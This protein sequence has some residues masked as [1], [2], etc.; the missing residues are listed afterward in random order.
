MSVA[1][2]RQKQA[3]ALQLFGYL[4]VLDFESTCWQDGKH[5][6]LEII[7]FPAVLMSTATGEILSEFHHYVLPQESPIL[8]SF[9]R[10]LTGITQD[11]VDEGIPLSLALSK[12]RHWLK[13]I[14]EQQRLVYNSAADDGQP[15]CTF[16]TWS[17]WDLG[18]CLQFE[19]R[20]KQLRKPAELNSWIDLRATYRKFYERKPKGLNG[21]L[22]DLGLSFEGRE[23]SGIVDA[24][25]TARLAYRMMCDG[26]VMSITKT[27]EGSVN[28][29]RKPAA[30]LPVTNTVASS[31]PGIVRSTAPGLVRHPA[32]SLVRHPAP[33]L[34]RPAAPSLVRH[35]APS[36]VRSAAQSLV[37]HTA[38]SLVRHPAPNLVRSAAPRLVR[39]AAPSLVRSAAPSLVRSPAPGSLMPSASGITLP[40]GHRQMSTAGAS[41]RP[42]TSRLTTE[43]DNKTG[44]C[45]TSASI[46]RPRV[47]MTVSKITTT[48]PNYP[49]NSPKPKKK[50]S[51]GAGSPFSVHEDQQSS[52]S[53]GGQHGTGPC[54]KDLTNLST[55]SSSSSVIGV[56][57]ADKGRLL[58]PAS[59]NQVVSVVDNVSCVKRP[60]PAQASKTTPVQ[61]G[62]GA[63]KTPLPLKP[64]GS[65]EMKRT[66]PMCT[67]GRRA[68]RKYVQNPGPNLGRTFFCCG[69]TP[70]RSLKSKGCN[71]FK[72]DLPEPGGLGASPTI[73]Q[74]QT[75]SGVQ[76]QHT[77][78][79][80]VGRLQQPD[81]STPHNLRSNMIAS[82]TG[83]GG[84]QK[85]LGLKCGSFKSGTFIRPPSY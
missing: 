33:N 78:Q 27:I 34:V 57:N 11:Q 70:G 45:G 35:P 44:K 59:V 53:N 31:F 73:R 42:E 74:N 6:T 65:S 64:P 17:D 46:K 67:C 37:R 75:R 10:E 13:R 69:A 48:G 7:E 49:T 84:A 72:W 80:V 14:G 30:P 51:S 9:C 20:R 81:F 1:V 32:P 23:H 56:R 50:H 41:L 18:V 71:F 24:K 21:A 60:L 38:P 82:S 63:F 36:L 15:R 26:C 2:R 40:P 25:N 4:V 3:K 54:L 61:S 79:P 5:R 8:S 68:K 66:P 62:C 16:V 19:A 83:G 47:V 52:V 85:T 43:A 55:E 39:P 22:Q 28:P 29:W 77:P 12:F 76:A 58:K